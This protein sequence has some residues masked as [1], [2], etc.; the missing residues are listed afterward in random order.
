MDVTSE[1]NVSFVPARTMITPRSPPAAIFLRFRPFVV[2]CREKR[3]AGAI[4]FPR[5][6]TK[7]SPWVTVVRE[8]IEESIQ[9]S[10]NT[11]YS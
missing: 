6:E 1:R 10:W 11:N 7:R 8:A 9:I 4:M 5:G 2:V 3:R